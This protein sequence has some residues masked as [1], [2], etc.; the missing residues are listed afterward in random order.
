[1][2][3]SRNAAAGGIVEVRLD[4]P[5][6]TLVGQTP[7]VAPDAPQQQPAAGAPQRRGPQTV[8]APLTPATGKHTIY[9]VFKNDKA[10]PNQVILQV[11][12]IDVQ[13]VAAN[14]TAAGK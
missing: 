1:M 7:L 9:F 2:A 11:M 10:G 14:S 3:S 12:G 5:D 4:A 8:V 13:Q 6:G